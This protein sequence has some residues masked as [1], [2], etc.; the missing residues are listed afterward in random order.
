MR[1]SGAGST[2]MMPFR[3]M[4]WNAGLVWEMARQDLLGRHAGTIGGL[5]WS[6]MN[7]AVTL[8]VYW[9]VFELVLHSQGENGISYAVFISCGYLPWTAFVD[10]VSTCSNSVTSR[11]YIVSKTVFPSEILPLVSVMS[12][13]LLHIVLVILLAVVIAAWTGHATPFAFQLGYYLF[14]MAFFALGLGLALAALNVLFRDIGQMTTVLLN[15]WFWLTPVVWPLDALPR[16]LRFAAS[17]NPM[18]YIAEGYRDSLFRGV[19]FW[20]KPVESACFWGMCLLVLAFGS[21]VFTR[22]RPEFA[23]LL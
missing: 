6:F 14:A 2:T 17:L 7:P 15:I 9:A 4:L 13:A 21:Y 20:A 3:V 19:P 16:N 8:C 12:S 11:R 23:E 22:L 18:V 10:M 1:A 5:L